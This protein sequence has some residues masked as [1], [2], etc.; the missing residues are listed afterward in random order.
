MNK[1]V[2]EWG[3]YQRMKYALYVC[4]SFSFFKKAF[5]LTAMGLSCLFTDLVVMVCGLNCRVPCGIL[6]PEPG[7]EPTS[8]ALEGRVL[9]T[10]L[11][12]KSPTPMAGM[13]WKWIRE[14]ESEEMA[15]CPW[16]SRNVGSMP[17]WLTH[18]PWEQIIKRFSFLHGLMNS[19]MVLV[20][21]DVASLSLGNHWYLNTLNY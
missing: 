14:S 21:K 9:T 17:L 5:F 19:S 6:L 16:R 11:P 13:A 20:N 2:K 3:H 10:G 18:N 15:H 7:I 12:V 8:P 1:W 4:I